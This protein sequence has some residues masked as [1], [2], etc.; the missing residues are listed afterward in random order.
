MP[1][2]IA[3]IGRV[4]YSTL[5][6]VD[7]AWSILNMWSGR[8]RLIPEVIAFAIACIA[9][10]YTNYWDCILKCGLGKN[11]CRKQCIL[12]KI[13]ILLSNIPKIY[14]VTN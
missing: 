9:T 1:S 11:I 5:G 7:M 10:L 13:P 8:E 2:G 3:D 12:I 14:E 4:W 6:I